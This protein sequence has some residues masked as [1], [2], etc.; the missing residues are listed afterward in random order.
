MVFLLVFM[1]PTYYQ[2][3]YLEFN[4]VLEISVI[5][6]WGVTLLQA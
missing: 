1:T 5:N 3:V 2:G 6:E 4:M